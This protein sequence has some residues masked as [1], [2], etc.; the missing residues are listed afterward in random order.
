[1]GRLGDHPHIVTVFDIGDE[2]GSPFI[3]SEYMAGGDVEGL[4]DAEAERRLDGARGRSRSPATSAAALEHAHGAASST[5]TSSPATS[6]S[7][8]DGTAKIGD[9]G[10]ADDRRP[11]AAQ[12]AGMMVGTVAYMPP[13][14]AL[15]RRFGPALGP[16]FARRHALRDADRPAAVPRRRR[17][18]D[19]L[20]AHQHRAGRAVAAQ[21]RG[22]RGPRRAGPA[23]CWRSARGRPPGRRRRGPRAP[24]RRCAASRPVAERDAGGRQ[25]ARPLAGGIFVGRE[26]EVEQLRGELDEALGGSRPGC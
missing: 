15:G 11:L 20:P 21:P 17:G 1:M 12:R 22:A 24:R 18:R 8:E 6:G 5:A 10:L 13:E 3:V 19:H 2:G 16:L 26:P 25:P 7:T 9:F 4:L 23:T 14:Q